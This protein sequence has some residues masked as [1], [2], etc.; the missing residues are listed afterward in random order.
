MI[1]EAFKAATPSLLIADIRFHGGLYVELTQTNQH[2]EYIY[3]NTIA[4]EN[5]EA[6]CGMA[7]DAPARTDKTSELVINPGK[8]G[9]VP[10]EPCICAFAY[11]V[12]CC[13]G[14]TV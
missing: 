14:F 8:C 13:K 1:N 9:A 5:Y 3:V 6:F 12:P 2:V 7:Y 10:G 11:T 4:T